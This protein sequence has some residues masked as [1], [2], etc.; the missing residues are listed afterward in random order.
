[1]QQVGLEQELP[2][3]RHAAWKI[4]VEFDDDIEALWALG[5]LLGA[6]RIAFHDGREIAADSRLDQVFPN[7]VLGLCPGLPRPLPFRHAAVLSFSQKNNS[8]NRGCNEFLKYISVFVRSI[9]K[10]TDIG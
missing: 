7:A 4:T 5:D 6:V 8:S 10:G 9:G 1:M 2:R 3:R